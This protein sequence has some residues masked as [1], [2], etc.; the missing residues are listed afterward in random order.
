MIYRRTE[1]FRLAFMELPPEIQRKILKAFALFKEDYRNPSLKIK[2]YEGI[3]EGRIDQ[4]YRFT[5]HWEKD[6]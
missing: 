5:F 2:G 1:R 4:Q 6:S 3:W